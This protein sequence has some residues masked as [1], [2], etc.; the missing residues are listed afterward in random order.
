MPHIHEQ[1]DFT[2]EVFV[3]Y[4]NRVLLRKH[5]KYKLWLS[6]GGHVEL[7]EDPN[8]AAVREVKE[9]VGLDVTL[10]RDLLVKTEDNDTYREL[11]PPKFL[12]RHTINE[13]H[14][15]VSMTYFVTAS[16]EV[17]INQVTEQ[18]ESIKWFA[19]KEKS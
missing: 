19:A 16:S 12:N 15:H 11:I 4:A 3:V 14:E 5:D 10:A 7:D 2:V 13:G 8:Q 9:E 18:S 17:I 6:V 1:I